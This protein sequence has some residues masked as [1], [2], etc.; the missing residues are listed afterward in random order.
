MK[1]RMRTMVESFREAVE[2]EVACRIR[3]FY[4]HRDD[5]PDEDVIEGLRDAV[6]DGVMGVF[7]EWFDTGDDDGPD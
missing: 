5:Y 2:A 6:G 7:H 3:H 4:K 1:P